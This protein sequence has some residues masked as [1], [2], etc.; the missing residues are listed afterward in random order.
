MH[1][2]GG[3]RFEYNPRLLDLIRRL[4]RGTIY[5][6]KGLPLA[7]EDSHVLADARQAYEA[8]GVSIASAC[9]N[10]SERCYPLG[11]KAFHVLGDARTGRNWSATNTS[12]VE[13]DADARLRGF[14]DHASTVKTIDRP[15]QSMYAIHRDYSELVP[16]LRHRRQPEHPAVVA[17]RD[18]PRDVHLTIDASLQLRVA[19]IVA[20]QARKAQGKAAAIVLDPDTGAVLASVSYPSPATT[21]AP[22][23]AVKVESNDAEVWLDRARYGA[24]P[25]GSTFKLVMALAAL[26]DSF[27]NGRYTCVRL[28]DGRIGAKI[29]G[30]SRPVRDDVLDTQPHGTIDM[31]EGLVHSCNA[32]FAQLAVSLGPEPIIRVA[33]RLKIGLSPNG[34]SEERVRQALPQVGYGQAQVVTSPLRMATVAAAVAADGFLRPPYVDEDARG[35]SLGEPIV[36]PGSA[37]L[38]GRFMRDVVTDGTGRSLRSHPS[39]IAGKTGTAEVAGRPSHGWFVGFAPYEP[40]SPVASRGGLSSPARATKKRI[41]FAIVIEHAGYG[42]LT[43]APAAGDIVS[44]ATDVGLIG[45]AEKK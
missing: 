14:D 4:P 35:E 36:D 28:P 3:R 25:P 13:R 18:R 5:D 39:A 44:A 38:L 2:D 29:S 37:R 43:A 23:S 8:L 16:V 30:W 19:S 10:P 15:G 17:F 40:A 27:T 45:A 33:D 22:A 6:R 42:G 1:A 32:Y 20:T 24:Y 41:A 12:Y 34:N 26:G 9:P 7:T 11:G 31:H 21:D